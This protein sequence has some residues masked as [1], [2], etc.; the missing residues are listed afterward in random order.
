MR[1]QGDQNSHSCLQ[2]QKMNYA[3]GGSD[4]AYKNPALN[5]RATEKKK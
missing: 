1:E 4:G 3:A 5:C 2:R